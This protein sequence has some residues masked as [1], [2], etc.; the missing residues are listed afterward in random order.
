MDL[1]PERWRW[2]CDYIRSVF[3]MEDPFQAKLMPAA[4][5]DGL[6]NIAVSPETGRFLSVLVGGL[7][8]RL[9]IEVGTLAGYSGIW[10]ARAMTPDARLLTIEI[11]P[12]HAAFAQRSFEQAAVAPR[13]QI[14]RSDALSA[15]TQ[16]RDQLKPASVDFVL[17]DAVKTEYAAYLALVRDLIR[18]G[19]YLIADNALAANW[20]LGDAPGTDPSRDAMDAFNRSL[21]RDPSFES[22]IVP[23]GN[24][25]LLARRR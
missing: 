6:P 9:G 22:I 14:I 7:N 17:L 8:A 20:W 23:I 16:L 24:G 19:G 25:V 1:T 15:L 4:V 13:I 10:L 12:K 5:A 11:D 18:P 2:T 3:A 21:A